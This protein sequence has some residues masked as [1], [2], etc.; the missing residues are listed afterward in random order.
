[1]KLW[2]TNI[3]CITLIL[4][5]LPYS[6]RAGSPDVD[7]LKRRALAVLE[8]AHVAADVLD[9]IAATTESEDEMACALA[10]HALAMLNQ[11][12]I[13]ATSETIEHVR[14]QL[15][16][17]I[18]EFMQHSGV[19]LSDL[20]AITRLPLI[21]SNAIASVGTNNVANGNGAQA[22]PTSGDCAIALGM[23]AIAAVQDAIAIGDTATVTFQNGIAIGLNS[24]VTGTDA[25]AM[26]NAATASGARALAIGSQDS[27]GSAA[28]AATASG[29]NAI[30]L[31]GSNNGN[32]GAAASGMASVALGGACTTVAGA[33]AS[34]ARAVAIGCGSVATQADSII[35]GNPN[36]VGLA[37][38][39]GTSSPSTTY[40]T[41]ARLTI[42]TSGNQ[43]AIAASNG[44][45]SAPAYSFVNTNT[46]VG[47]YSPGQNQLALVTSNTTRLLI[48]STGSVS[49]YSQYKVHAYKTGTQTVTGG[50]TNTVVTFVTTSPGFD[51]N[52]NFNTG[53]STYTAPIS[54]YYWVS[55]TITTLAG[56]NIASPQNRVVNMRVNG[57]NVAGYAVQASDN[58]TSGTASQYLFL[59]DTGLVKLNQNDTLQIVYNNP[60]TATD[61]IQATGTH[62]EI[63][64]MS[65][66]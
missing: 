16:Q 32:A 64:F 28:N 21:G 35:L 29:V 3:F 2:V 58:Y 48:D 53:T 1:M 8:E 55:T 25:V 43:N 33:S 13:V 40:T 59:S 49:Y 61:T 5:G 47:M 22:N 39:I 54:G 66:V 50:S 44:T 46:S 6:C 17:E 45:I 57:A 11:D 37:V 26:G 52:G 56:Y 62:L 38:A 41:T 7:R 34:G 15:T 4:A 65:T 63:H 12:K 9:E 23:N 30:A 60:S 19:A 24:V 10:L 18:L 20:H 14:V 36:T 42:V 31:G 51:I 27:I